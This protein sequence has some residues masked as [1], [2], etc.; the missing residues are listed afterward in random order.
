M[1]SFP[2]WA[3]EKAVVVPY[4]EVW[5][6]RAAEERA[7][8]IEV[9]APWLVEG[10]EH[11][12]STAVP[13]LAAKPIVDLMASVRDH[14]DDAAHAPLIDDGWHL[15]PPELDVRPWRRFFIRPDSAGLHR[16]A[17]LHVVS[18]GHR[19]WRDQIAFRDALRADTA[20][21]SEYA[22]LK[23]RLSA[24]HGADREAYTAGKSEFV[25]RVLRAC[26]SGYMPDELH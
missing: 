10:V 9:L 5:A 14:T 16:V 23:Q 17:H 2:A 20:L 11:V 18:P 12:G 15:V 26:S 8:L 19:R 4:Q 6:A 13:G 1:A 25:G 7:R 3:N 21:A 22:E 24:D